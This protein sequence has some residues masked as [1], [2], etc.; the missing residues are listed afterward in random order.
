MT[1]TTRRRVTATPLYPGSLFPEDGR[2][3]VIPDSGT[4]AALAAMEGDNAWFC[5]E[6][7]STVHKRW[8]DGDG[9]EMWTRV[10]EQ[11]RYR[12]YV[13]EELTGAAD[14]EAWPDADDYRTLL[15][16]M[17]GNKW[18]TVVRTRRGNFQPVEREDVVLSAAELTQ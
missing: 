15:A 3:R 1:E 9:G 4:T 10:S 13:G 12:I 11:G 8:T 7:R 2:A 6:V 14:I 5:I 18:T 17:D 16:N